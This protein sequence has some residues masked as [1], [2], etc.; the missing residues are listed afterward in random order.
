MTARHQIPDVGSTAHGEST[1][2]NACGDAAAMS[3]SGQRTARGIDPRRPGEIPGATRDSYAS[4]NPLTIEA[5][6]PAW[7]RGGVKAEAVTAGETAPLWG[8][9]GRRRP[10]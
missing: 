4:P 6:F 8:E 7:N 2:P 1:F 3:I 9:P 5:R 10:A